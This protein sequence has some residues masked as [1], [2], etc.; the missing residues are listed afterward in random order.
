MKTQTTAYLKALEAG[1]K[2]IIYAYIKS[3][4][5]WRCFG[6]ETPVITH[7][8]TDINVLE[9]QARVLAFGDYRITLA[10][11]EGSY[12]ALFQQEMPSYVL[13][14]D[15]ADYYFTNILADEIL[16]NGEL[17]IEQGFDTTGF[18]ASDFT[19]LYTGKIERVE[20]SP[21]RLLLHTIQAV[22]T[23][24]P[25]DPSI[26]TTKLYSLTTTSETDPAASGEF[27][28]EE[29]TTFIEETSWEITINFTREAEAEE[30]LFEVVEATT[31]NTSIEIGVNSDGNYYLKYAED[32]TSSTTKTIEGPAAGEGNQ[33]LTVSVD[34]NTG[35]VNIDDGSG[36]STTTKLETDD[37]YNYD[38]HLIASLSQPKDIL[39]DV[40]GYIYILED[41][42]KKLLKYDSAGNYVSEF[43]YGTILASYMCQDTYGNFYLASYDSTS[44]T[45]RKYNSAGVLQWT[46]GGGGSG[47]GQF[48]DP[49][50]AGLA[51]S[52]GNVL[53]V[54][55]NGNNRIQYFDIGTGDYVGQW[56]SAGSGDG[57]FST[58]KD[59]TFDSLGN[60][61]VLDAGNNRIQVFSAPGVFAYKFGEG[62]FNTPVS[63]HISN[64]SQVF[65]A[66][67]GDN[68]VYWY[69]AIH[70]L[71]GVI[72]ASDANF[73]GVATDTVTISGELEDVLYGSDFVASGSILRYIWEEGEY[74][75]PSFS[76]VSNSIVKMG[77]GNT[78]SSIASVVFKGDDDTPV[79]IYQNI[80]DDDATE[81]PELIGDGSLDL[82]LDNEAVW[83]EYGDV[84]AY[85]EEIETQQVLTVLDN[86]PLKT[87]EEYPSSNENVFLPLLYGDLF[88]NTDYD[89]GVSIAPC[90]D[91]VNFVYCVS[92]WP[93]L[94]GAISIF[95][96]GE[97]F[98]GSYTFNP[99]NNYLGLGAIATLTFNSDPGGDVSVQVYGKLTTL[100]Y[101]LTNPI[102]II[103]DLIDY[104]A[105]QANVPAWK[106]DELS[107]R[108]ARE[109]SY[110]R[111]YTCAGVIAQ[112]NTLG[113][114]IKS[115]L[116]SF[117]GTFSFNGNGEMQ[118]HL[119]PSEDTE[120]I[121]IELQEY[122]AIS[123][124]AMQTIE[125]LCNAVNV[126]YAPCYDT[127]DRRY[128]SGGEVSYGRTFEAEDDDSITKYGKV[129]WDDLNF[130]FTRNTDT[131][132]NLILM[133]FARYADPIW[134]ITYSGQDCLALP[135]DLY[136]QVQADF[137]FFPGQT[138]ICELREKTINLDL[139]SS[140]L[141]LQVLDFTAASYNPLCAIYILLD[142]VYIGSDAVYIQKA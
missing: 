128:S 86:L 54:C 133:I 89:V 136:D 114:W 103:E 80:G 126:N 71:F 32:I 141:I 27:T 44:N 35:D 67:T 10:T 91:T 29:L 59:L 37:K 66:D 116:A 56:G 81:M 138:A 104:A 112:V 115:I 130:N 24:E 111:G 5:A 107:F 40:S 38:S 109:I 36:T 119:F 62:D 124:N 20:I 39:V 96:D 33:T 95:I 99:N 90:I 22:Q 72:G 19:R 52:P 25:A 97:P 74:K 85:T 13:T 101:F 21:P 92:G 55:D 125:N 60:C 49:G 122:D 77:R 106:K 73:F 1:A 58:P 69:T 139:F 83:E 131:V 132:E 70:D 110:Q 18:T 14:L 2:P 50:P 134:Q 68:C 118:I 113:Y 41:G 135:L 63:I 137:R 88:E 79:I 26:D 94:G 31:S 140:N 30:V 43:S 11:G 15:N 16:L 6:K 123:L 100:G 108:L 28:H 9:W 129:A 4:M 117:L 93:L 51:I 98:T 57:Q 78:N 34:G 75:P 105:A 120:N 47:D 7:L 64:L 53:Y 121:Q 82:T 12:L 17:I 8:R 65:V 23:D 3:D 46:I 84:Q 61:F 48:G 102:D 87:A 42:N 127:I 142:Q 76:L 45:V